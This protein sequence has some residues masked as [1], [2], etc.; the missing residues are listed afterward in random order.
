[1]IKPQEMQITQ[2]ACKGELRRG[3][4]MYARAVRPPAQHELWRFNTDRR[5]RGT[6]WLVMAELF[7]ISNGVGGAD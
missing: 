3:E 6:N 2:L 5:F 4:T 7:R 1:M